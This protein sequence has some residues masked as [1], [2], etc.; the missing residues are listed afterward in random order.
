M[1]SSPDLL[2]I[3]KFVKIYT[4][5]NLG[6]NESISA[7]AIEHDVASDTLKAQ[8]T[9]TTEKSSANVMYLISYRKIIHE[10]T[11][12]GIPISSLLSCK[13]GYQCLCALV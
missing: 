4:L 12:R 6:K 3:I 9:K 13:N 1:I 11:I 5:V 7:D 10:R 8:A 2:N